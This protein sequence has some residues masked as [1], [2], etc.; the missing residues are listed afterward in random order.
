MKSANPD[1]IANNIAQG[2]DT[3][4]KERLLYAVEM[5][6]IREYIESLPLKY[7][8]RIGSTGQGLS[9]GQKQRILIA[10]A[11]YRDPD[12]IFLDEATNALDTNNEREIQKKLECFLKKK[13][14]VIVAHRLSTVKNRL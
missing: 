14:V 2:D 6:N 7:N 9:Q 1:T 11:I 10:R 3:V 4:D 13:T 8:S 12:Y 5:A